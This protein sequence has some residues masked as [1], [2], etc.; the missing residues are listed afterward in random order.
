VTPIEDYA[1]LG[2]RRSA[3]LVSRGG[4][5]DWWCTPRFDSPACFA[6]LLGAPENGRFLLAPKEE[7]VS[8]RHYRDGSLVLET[9]HATKTGRV[10][11]VECLVRDTERPT[12]VRL[13]EGIEGTVD[14]HLELIVRF[15][16]G[17]VVPW[18]RRVDG[19]WRAVAGP[20]GLE[21]AT[22][23]HVHGRRMSTVADFVVHAG[24]QVP[25]ALGWFPSH[26]PQRVKPNAA[27]LIEQ[28][29]RGWVEWTSRVLP[30]SEWREAVTRSVLTLE[31]LTYAP[32]GGIVAAP[33]TSLPEAIGGSRNWDYRFCW[34]RDATLTLEALLA[35]GFREEADRWRN[36]LL[37]TVA[38][39]PEKLQ[40]MYGVDGER[41][42]TE[43]DLDWLPGYGGSRPVRSG[44]CAHT[45][46]QLDTYGELID[47]LYQ[48]ARHGIQP[49]GNTWEV[50][51]LVLDVLERRWTEPD[52]GIWEVRGRR[53]HFTLSK[54]L[55]WVAFDRAVALVEHFDLDGP[56]D[57]WRAL[58]D[59]IHAEV[60][61]RSYNA[62]K[63]AFV[64]SYGSDELD[65]ATLLIPAVGFLPATDPRVLGTIDAIERELIVDG[66]VRRYDAGNASIDGIGE[67]EGVFLPCSFWMAEALALA[68]RGDKARALFERLIGMANDV[69]LYSE[70][71]DPVHS[72]LLGNFP[73]AFTHL[74]LVG[75][76][77]TLSPPS[78]STRRRRDRD[79]AQPPYMQRDE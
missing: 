55:C 44:N 70:E 3:A 23:V 65:A 49:S 1:L 22:P 37:R 6:A 71:Y 78:T 54:V 7:A 69:G 9:E 61:E 64:Q 26:D 34:V 16:Y 42:L 28:T 25:F 17:S 56:V 8:T 14:M 77:Y 38:G 53:R 5:V 35:S 59:T 19:A 11:V 45:Q 20:D 27:E 43:L 36:W 47:V 40:T 4:S 10:R 73:Q 68:G 60:S 33:T 57:R 51:R 32:T 2:D 79:H 46:L 13:V 21:M 58:R 12:L 63:G 31:A 41:R 52:E 18:V 50:A 48:A 74:A 72:R 29:E 75:A 67:P 30:T 24:E 62:S 39:D 76:A 15:D 66:L